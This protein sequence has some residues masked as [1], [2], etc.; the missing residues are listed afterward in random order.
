MGKC[1]RRE[2]IRKPENVFKKNQVLTNQLNPSLATLGRCPPVFMGGGQEK[3]RKQVSYF[4]VM[5]LKNIMLQ[6]WC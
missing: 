2:K 4:S 1:S 5:G 3:E 6:I